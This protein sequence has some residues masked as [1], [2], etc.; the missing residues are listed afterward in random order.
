MCKMQQLLLT[1]MACLFSST[2]LASIN[3][4]VEISGIDKQMKENVGLLL[5]IEQQKDHA[6][7][8]EGRMRRLHKKAAQE[9][10]SALQPFGYYRP[11]IKSELTKTS[12]DTW[13]ATYNITLG[14]PL[15]IA[16]FEL[17]ISEEMEKD[18]EFQTLIKNLKLHKGDVLNQPEYE[19]IKRNLARLATERGYFSARFTEHR[20]EVDLDAYEAHIHL[21]YEGGPRYR[22]GEVLLNQDVLD[23]DLLRRY[24]PFQTGAP[25]TLNEL[26]DFQQAL[27]DSDYFRTV[28]VSPGQPQLESG[29][30]PITVALTARN[31]HRFSLGMGYGTD[32]GPRAKFGWEI[33]R[34]NH[35]GHRFNTELKVSQVGYSISAHYRVPVLNPRTDQMIYSAGEVNEKTDSSDSTVRTISASLNRSHGLWRE[36]VFINYQ[37]E[38]YRVANDSGKSTLLIPGVNW[39]RTWASNFI[40]TID[41]LRFDISFRGANKILIS[42]NNFFQLQGGVKGI[43]PLGR[44]NRLIARGRLGGTW[45]DT[46]HELPS[47]VRFFSG[48]TQSVRSYAYQSLGPVDASGKVVGGRY[49]MVGSVEYEH[50]LGGKWG[51][52]LFIDG[53]NAIDDIADKLEQGAG[54][55][56]RWQS[57]IGPVR[58]DLAS[59]ITVDGYPWRLHINIGPDL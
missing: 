57:P 5:S 22:F 21:K 35:R 14:P 23:S 29:E 3:L 34:L 41:A 20:V 15:I 52:A 46:F 45:T 26:I 36:S 10:A 44:R 32:T 49:L 38:E 16:Q 37:Q 40:Y 2:L 39:S 43:N 50:S 17:T 58:F 7:M 48:G 13:Q 6:L 25:Y 55:G 9:I 27:N 24:I 11:E 47:S 51:V 12:P 1:L 28:E 30:I 59:A 8:S 56:V 19:N 54:F 31:R 42:D 33:P 4:N 53:G 18:P